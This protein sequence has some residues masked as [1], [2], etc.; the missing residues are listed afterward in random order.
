M[1]YELNVEEVSRPDFL[2]LANSFYNNSGLPGKFKQEHFIVSWQKFY[3]LNIGRIWV[4]ED[5]ETNTI[6]GAIA[7]LVHPDLYDGELVAQELFWYVE[8]GA[9]FTSAVHLYKR[10][11]DWAKTKG[12]KRLNMACVCNQHMASLRRF[13]EKRGFRPVDVSYFKDLV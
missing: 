12:A 8:P 3:E 9:G 13:Y 10:L 6:L 7:C 1:I 2:R 11:E 4:C 5:S